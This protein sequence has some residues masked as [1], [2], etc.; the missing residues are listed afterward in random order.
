MKP[1][2][3]ET[4]IKALT[5]RAEK[6]LK[7]PKALVKELHSAQ[8]KLARTQNHRLTEIKEQLAVLIAW[9]Q[10]ILSGAYKD[11]QTKTP[12]MIIAG[13]LYFLMPL[14]S[15]PDFLLGWGYIDDVAVI[16]FIY[17]QL[18]TEIEHY[19]SWRQRREKANGNVQ[20]ID[21]SE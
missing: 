19:L 13:I 1:D 5:Q 8:D 7:H 20:S 4:R 18:T 9:A 15:I 14:D 2:R 10:D 6:L 16:S 21:H 11:Y 17:R 3:S 12:V